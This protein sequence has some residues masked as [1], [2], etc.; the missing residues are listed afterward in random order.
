MVIDDNNQLDILDLN[1]ISTL[2]KR[3]GKLKNIKKRKKSSN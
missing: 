2:Q 3:R 1:E